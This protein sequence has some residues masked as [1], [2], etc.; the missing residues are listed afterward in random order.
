MSEHIVPK[1]T[2]I[3]VWATLL[4]MTLITTLVAFV[5][6]GRFNTVVALAIATFKA[7]LV[8]LF[9]MG[10]KYTARLTK[11][12]IICG[13]FFL[14]LLLGFSIVDYLSRLWPA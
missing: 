11:V 12:V 9:F 14:A 2:Y 3:A 5:D 6:L 13:L 7:T 10:A 1:R 8:V 4:A